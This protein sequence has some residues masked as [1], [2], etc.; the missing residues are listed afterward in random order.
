MPGPRASRKRRGT[1]KGACSYC[2]RAHKAGKKGYSCRGTGNIQPNRTGPTAEQRYAAE[3][4]GLD[5]PR[6]RR[7]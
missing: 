1:G 7:S 6:G 4:T 5:A 3:H 2:G